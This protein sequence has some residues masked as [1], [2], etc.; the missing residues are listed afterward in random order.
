MFSPTE[1]KRIAEYD[2]DV[3]DQLR[4]EREYAKRPF[5]A[6]KNQFHD[7]LDALEV[8]AMESIREANIEIG[9][10]LKSKETFPSQ[11]NSDRIDFLVRMLRYRIEKDHEDIERWRG[12]A[13]AA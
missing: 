1:L 2:Q 4:Q 11:H 6:G 13:K 9:V 3:E 12:Y 5:T 10:L 7:L 8:E